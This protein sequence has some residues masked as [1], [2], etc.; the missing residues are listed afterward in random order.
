MSLLGRGDPFH[1]AAAVLRGWLRPG[2]PARSARTPC[3]VIGH[4]GAARFEAENTVAAFDR[5]LELGADTVEADVSVTADGRFALW[6][7][8]DPDEKV[9]LARQLGAER[10]AY[11]PRVPQAGSPWRRPVREL[12]GEELDGHYGYEPVGA[13]SSTRKVRIAWLEDLRAWAARSGVAHIFLDLK[14]AD[15]Q[16]EA[17]DALVRLLG[18]GSQKT[19]FH[20]LS[21]RGSIVR[22]LASASAGSPGPLRVS[23]DFE[24]P[25]PRLSELEPTGARDVSLG[26]GGRFWPGYKAD[27]G[28][29]LR[30]REAGVFESVVGWTINRASRLQ[31]LVNAGIDGLLTDE[32]AR[33]RRIVEAAGRATG[34]SRGPLPRSPRH[35]RASASR[36][37]RARERIRRG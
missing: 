22:A 34:P 30:A 24:L 11:R 16:T 19:T 25:V 17:A 13:S 27:V 33:L 7:D 20:L 4:R 26:L 1:R 14:L 28:R 8:A 18:E 37:A 9:A 5:A 12:T 31:L 35:L 36:R 10:L 32:P 15:D 2:L 23:A 29:M 3:L 6:H 21:P